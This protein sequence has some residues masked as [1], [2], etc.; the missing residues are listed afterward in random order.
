MLNFGPNVKW[1]E[2]SDAVSCRSGQLPVEI[3]SFGQSA[4]GRIT[5]VF[6]AR[7]EM[8]NDAVAL[9]NFILRGLPD[10]GTAKEQKK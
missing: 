5:L 10:Q 1:P 2:F 3:T 6:S 4:N 9:R 7:D 8:R